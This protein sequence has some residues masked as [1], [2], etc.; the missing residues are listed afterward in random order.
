MSAPAAPSG[1]TLLAQFQN[2]QAIATI[3]VRTLTGADAAPTVTGIAGVNLS[4]MLGEF[5]GVNT[6]AMVDQQTSGNSFVSPLALTLPAPNL[7][8]GELW[9]SCCVPFYSAAATETFLPNFNNGTAFTTANGAT[10]TRSHY[11]FAYAIGNANAAADSYSFGM[12]TTNLSACPGVGASL[13]VTVGTISGSAAVSVGGVT[14]AAAGVV[15]HSVTGSAAV[16]VGA[17][18]VAASGVVTVP[19]VSG[20]ASVV[21]GAVTV[22][23]TS[24]VPIVV[25]GGT[26]TI[27]TDLASVSIETDVSSVSVETDLASVTITTE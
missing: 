14:V 26:V 22:H 20:T 5:S 19:T 9:L 10:S 21:I 15:T 25:V 18:S 7:K 6:T 13:Q 16:S 23:A 27:E 4:A 17:V 24:H 12:T 2:G 3:F 11:G 1:W 8:A